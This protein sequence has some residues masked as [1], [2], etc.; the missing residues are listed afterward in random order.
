MA[1]QSF[2][3][4]CG[5]IVL[6]SPLRIGGGLKKSSDGAPGWLNRLSVQLLISAQVT[7]LPFVKSA[8]TVWSLLGILSLSLSAPP[9]LPLSLSLS[10]PPSLCLSQNK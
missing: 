9:S 8:L 10:L 1:K 7:I 2:S 4:V 5:P 6:I 3:A